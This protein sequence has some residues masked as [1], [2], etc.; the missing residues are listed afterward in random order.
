MEESDMVNPT[1]VSAHLSNTLNTNQKNP[2]KFT[3]KKRLEN[4]I[5][6]HTRNNTN[7]LIARDFQSFWYSCFI[8]CVK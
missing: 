8:Y 2:S 5:I 4:T 7:R 3:K 1:H 6:N